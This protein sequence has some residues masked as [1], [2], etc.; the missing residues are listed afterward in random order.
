MTLDFTSVG[1]A[2]GQNLSGHTRSIER[3]D[4]GVG[5]F[6]SKLTI[7]EQDVYQLT[8]DFATPAGG[9]LTG[10]QSNSLFVLGDAS[11]TFTFAEG[12]GGAT[13]WNA[14]SQ[15]TNPV[16]DGNTYTL[17]TRGTAEVYV[18]S[19][20]AIT[21]VTVGTAAANTLAGTAASEVI[22]GGA[23]AD[24]IFGGAGN[25]TLYG[26][27]L[28]STAATSEAGVK[29]IFAYTL[30]ANTAS[31][32]D[33]IK[34][35]QVGTD[36]LYL[37]NTADTF[38]GVPGGPS[39]SVAVTAVA[40]NGSTAAYAAN[41]T[42]YQGFNAA[43]VPT[44]TTN[45]SIDNNLSIRDLTLADSANQYVTFGTDGLGN[46]RLTVVAGTATSTITLEGVQYE[47]SATAASGKYG[48]LA[49]L[50]GGGSETR[51]LYLT[52][53]PFGAGLATLP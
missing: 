29:D 6:A 40:P 39:S 7:A 27:A 31:G 15:V 33:V 30:T 13:G 25:D 17:F 35:F 45:N 5:T 2:A 14:A 47:A 4:L 3:I 18:S 20:V 11:D 16:G 52:N 26:G 22:A 1:T 44:A 38:A 51:V 28:G 50:M 49:E 19:A 12:V 43:A 21:G 32:S 34:D 23:G 24:V 46:V 42:T 53:D 48:S 8:G 36:R 9:T 41:G 37:V 10:R